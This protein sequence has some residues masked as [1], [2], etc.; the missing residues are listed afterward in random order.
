[1]EE[2]DLTKKRS[3]RIQ[4]I[5][6]IALFAVA[7]LSYFFVPGVRKMVGTITKMFATGDF[8]VVKEFVASYGAYAAAVSFMLMIAQSIAAP[9][10]AFLI[11]F[12]NANLFGWWKGGILSW[13]ERQYVSA[14]QEFSDVMCARDLQ[15][16]QDSSR[17]M[18]SLRNME[19]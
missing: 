19:E 14:S 8:T 3:R 5:V 2:K 15:A 16:R 9:L 4:Q 7:I 18:S 13:L 1:M 11:T 12:A 10:P 17:L 6:V